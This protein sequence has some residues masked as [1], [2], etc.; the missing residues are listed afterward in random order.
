M[1]K[2]GHACLQEVALL[3]A[4]GEL[5]LLK[6]RLQRA[7]IT[8]R[9]GQ[10]KFSEAQ[11][12]GTMG[13]KVRWHTIP[14]C[15]TAVRPAAHS[16]QRRRQRRRH[17]RHR[18]LTWLHVVAA[19]NDGDRVAIFHHSCLAH[20]C[21]RSDSRGSKICTG[22]GQGGGGEWA[23]SSRCRR[24]APQNLRLRCAA[25]APRPSSAASSSAAAR[26]VRLQK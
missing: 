25:T 10:G 7:C 22:R 20:G 18:Q 14:G 9:G 21:N 2:T 24:S 11:L 12:W 5:A 16:S 8:A 19:R 6:L 1:C 3:V 23:V 4:G 26:I 15:S 13:L 17:V